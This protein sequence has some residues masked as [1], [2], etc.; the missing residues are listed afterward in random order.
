MFDHS[1][2]Y[3]TG[4]YWHFIRE[5]FCQFPVMN[6]TQKLFSKAG[7]KFMTFMIKWFSYSEKGD[8]TRYQLG[9]KLSLRAIFDEEFI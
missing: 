7:L 8:W 9:F 2:N 4:K 1:G 3:R 6:I 5:L